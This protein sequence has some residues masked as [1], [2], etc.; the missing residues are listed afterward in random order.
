MQHLIQLR[1]VKIKLKEL[2]WTGDTIL[3][4]TLIQKLAWYQ[5]PLVLSQGQYSTLS[6]LWRLVD[7]EEAIPQHQISRGIR[8]SSEI[9][10]PPYHEMSRYYSPSQMSQVSHFDIFD[11]DVLVPKKDLQNFN[12]IRFHAFRQYPGL[13][14]MIKHYESKLVYPTPEHKHLVSLGSDSSGRPIWIQ[15]A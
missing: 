6:F 1:D 11:A 15:D 9:Q 14:H 8:Q 5:Y 3:S 12:Q 13:L 10:Q 2:G 7:L 4:P